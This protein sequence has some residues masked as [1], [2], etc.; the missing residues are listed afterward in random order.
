MTTLDQTQTEQIA[1]QIALT[2]SAATAVQDLMARRNLADHALR[3]FVSGGGCSGLQYGMAFEGRVRD[4]DTIFEQHGVKIVVDEVSI[5][6]LRGATVDY[7]EEMMGS[8]F[9]ISNPN[10]VSTCGCGQSFRTD[11]N[12]G[13]PE[14]CSCG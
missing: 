4:E 3:V 10:A 6:Y 14:G 5:N 13:S 8:G 7:V 12:S 1:E 11:K 2:E 9:K